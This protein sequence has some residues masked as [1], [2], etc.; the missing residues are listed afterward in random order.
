MISRLAMSS[1]ERVSAT[2]ASSV[3]SVH[4]LVASIALTA[5]VLLAFG[6]SPA[7]AA[8]EYKDVCEASITFCAEDTLTTAAGV[9]VDNSTGPSK[10]DVYV[11]NIGTSQVLK[12]DSS[13]KPANFSATGK[14][15]LGGFTEPNYIAISEAAHSSGDIF[16]S[17]PA[18]KVVD[19]FNAEGTSLG[20]MTLAEFHPEGVAVNPVNGDVY[21]ADRAEGER[22]DEFE[23]ESAGKWKLLKSFGSG[24]VSTVD[25]LATDSAGNVYVTSQGTSIKE[26]DS[27]GAPV[28]NSSTTNIVDSEAPQA[29]AVDPSNDHIFVGEKEASPAYQIAEYEAPGDAPSAT[30]GAGS[31]PASGG[32][33]G[34]AVNGGTHTVYASA[35]EGTAGLIFERKAAGPTQPLT[36]EKEGT[37]AAEGTVE[38]EVVGSGTGPKAC[39]PA[40]A[41]GAEVELTEKAGGT[42]F[43]GWGG[44][45]SG[46]GVCKVTMSKPIVVKATFT[47]R[48]LAEFPVTV[49]AVTGEGKVT[50]ATI[51]CTTGGVGTPACTEEA[52]E[53]TSVTLTA[54]PKAGW[55]LKEWTGKECAGSDASTCKF[56][57]PAEAVEEQAVFV[58]VTTSPLT[59]FV[60]GEGEVSS[61]PAGIVACGP[62]TGTCTDEFEGAVTLTAT[63]KPLS[64]YVFAGWLGCKHT[65]AGKCEVDVTVASEVTAVFLK[66]G[67]EGEKGEQG[68]KGEKGGKGAKGETGASGEAG[69]PGETGTAGA[70]GANGAS[71]TA[72]AQ[73][74]AGPAGPE[75]P[76][77]KVQIVTCKKVGKK[78]KCTTKTVSGTVKFTTSSTRATLSRHGIVYATGTASN[79]RGHMRLRLTPS[80]GLRPGSYMLTLVGGAGRHETIRSES[81]TLR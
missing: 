38:C 32:S 5:L 70:A 69:A 55:K 52:K 61:S 27:A 44:E 1:L 11:V 6:G 41:E 26:F 58:E 40:Y 48:V 7:L 10:G 12:F 43:E 63:P 42:T 76:A 79:A 39:V 35:I 57:M 3:R 56:T 37:G 25:S 46:T 15:E 18:A 20:S 72:G 22:I 8:E 31:F 24:E 9:A 28:I 66:E 19:Q 14:P 2:R 16:V 50:G 68:E 59:V 29:V 30:F 34:L 80:R 54:T 77:G 21:V 17:D 51:A 67:V 65:G 60:T 78:Q 81:V 62:L 74:P 4:K 64:G 71:G 49:T 53:T 13:G 75:G 47:A 23:E 36:I 33:Y 45:C 73:G